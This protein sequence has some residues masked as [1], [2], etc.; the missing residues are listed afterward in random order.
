MLGYDRFSALRLRYILPPAVINAAR[1]YTAAPDEGPDYF[2]LEYMGGSWFD[3]A[4]DGATLLLPSECPSLVGIIQISGGPYVNTTV[5]R[6][7]PFTGPFLESN[8]AGNANQALEALD[9]ALRV[10]APEG[11]LQELAAGTVRRFEFPDRARQFVSF[12]LRAPDLY[13]I[14]GVVHRQEGLLY[15]EIRRPDLIRVN[16]YEKGDYDQFLT[17]VFDE[18]LKDGM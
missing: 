6:G 18:G 14:H 9:L 10:G 3:E 8:W 11:A 13:H 16:E 1:F 7:Q 2:D 12:A 5:V 4:I 15:L 17:D